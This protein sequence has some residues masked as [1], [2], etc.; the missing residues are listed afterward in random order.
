MAHHGCSGASPTVL[1]RRQRSGRRRHLRDRA[2]SRRRTWRRCLRNTA[3]HYGLRNA[4]KHIGWYLAASGRPADTVK[5]WRRRL[6]TIGEPARRARRLGNLLRR[7]AGGR[8]NAE[9]HASGS[10]QAHAGTSSTICCSP[11][12]PHPI[13]VLGDDDR[14]LYANA[15]AEV[16]LLARARACSSARHC[17]TSSPSRARSR[18]WSARCGAPAPPSTSTASRSACRARACRSWSTYS[19]APC[20]TTPR[21][22][23][24]MLQQRSMA[25]MIERQLTHRAAARSVSGLASVLAHEIKNPLSGIRGAAQ[26]LEP[27]LQGR[28]PRAGPAHLHRDRSHS[29]PGRSH[30]SVRRRAPRGGRARQHPSGARPREAAGRNRFRRG[31]Q[32]RRR[33]RPLAAAAGRA[34][35]TS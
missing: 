19:R 3:P 20:P 28:R 15:A 34:V 24:L 27:G 32:D 33:V 16:L 5:A 13:L 31:R 4:R 18:R 12:L 35:A 14:V 2:Q 8:M 17:P 1:A 9:P 26:L 23:V 6:C 21:L 11:V 30:G 7:G 25:Q 10:F 22:I 29:Q